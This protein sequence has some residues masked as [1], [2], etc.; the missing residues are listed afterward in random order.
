MYDQLAHLL[1]TN[2][3][4][5]ENITGE[6]DSTCKI[7]FVLCFS[8][9]NMYV[10]LKSI[11]GS[12]YMRVLKEFRVCLCQSRSSPCNFVRPLSPV[13]LHD[14]VQILTYI[15][16]FRAGLSHVLIHSWDHYLL[17]FL[18]KFCSC[19]WSVPKLDLLIFTNRKCTM[20]VLWYKEASK[21]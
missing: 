15:T 19:V 3:P 14:L 13:H 6:H 21:G 7:I 1:F 5:Y 17:I 10:G 11:V 12:R 8:S 20:I 16:N 18:E 4:L 9:I 2:S